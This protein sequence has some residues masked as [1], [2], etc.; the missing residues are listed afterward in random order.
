MRKDIGAFKDWLEQVEACFKPYPIALGFAL[1]QWCLYWKG[2]RDG[3]LHD[4]AMYLIDRY[5]Y[6][7]YRQED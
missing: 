6:D 4:C 7:G 2:V 1:E 3:R 5:G